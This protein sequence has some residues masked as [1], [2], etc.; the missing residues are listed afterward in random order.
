MR[1][2]ILI[3]GF[4]GLI[5][6]FNG[7]LCI[8]LFILFYEKKKLYFFSL[9]LSDNKR[10]ETNQ[11]TRFAQDIVFEFVHQCFVIH[12]SLIGVEPVLG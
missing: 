9:L 12:I 10:L 6:S 7:S 4:K 1:I 8:L 2:S 3:L 5:V 11:K